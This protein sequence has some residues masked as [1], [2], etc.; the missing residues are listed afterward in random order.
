MLELF[1]DCCLILVSHMHMCK[2]RFGRLWDIEILRYDQFNYRWITSHMI[3]FLKEIIVKGIKRKYILFF[4][5]GMTC[6]YNTHIKVLCTVDG[7]YD[8]QVIIIYKM[9]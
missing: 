6:M 5:L 2:L 7:V 4:F 9:R 1:G 8:M 3:S